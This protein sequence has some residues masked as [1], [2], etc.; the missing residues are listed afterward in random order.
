[1]PLGY[2]PAADTGFSLTKVL[3][4]GFID[5]RLRDGYSGVGHQSIETY[6]RL[7]GIPGVVEVSLNPTYGFWQG[8]VRK[9]NQ[10]KRCELSMLLQ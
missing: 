7:T 3:C 6:L 10:K 5:R 9:H 2:A 8:P 1:M 4:S